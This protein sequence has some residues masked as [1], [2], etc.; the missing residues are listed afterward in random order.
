MKYSWLVIGLL[1]ASLCVY[2][3]LSEDRLKELE[4]LV[5]ID[6][7]RD[8]DEEHNEQKRLKLSIEFTSE[9]EGMKEI[10]IR[11]AVELTDKK[12]KQVYR[13]EK[14]GRFGDLLD[15]HEGNYEGEGYWEL[16]MPCGE[17]DKLKVTAYVVQFGVMDG[18]TFVPF[19]TECDHV[20]SYDELM[21]RSAQVF[22]NRC[23]LLMTVMVDR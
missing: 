3:E 16:H 6:N 10:R 1:L 14:M 5:Q 17:L 9:V 13:V 11:T 7:V 21:S 18:D 22:P 12:T 19:Q 4:H 2:G 20:K 8:Y 23:R 15:V